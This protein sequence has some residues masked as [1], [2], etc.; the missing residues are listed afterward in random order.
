MGGNAEDTAFRPMCRTHRGRKAFCYIGNCIAISYITKTLREDATDV[1]KY[2]A[3]KSLRT[4]ARK[5]LQSI[6]LFFI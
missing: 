6:S 3:S 4:S 1:Q 5:E 2:D